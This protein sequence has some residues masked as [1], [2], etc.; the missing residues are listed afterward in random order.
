MS[1]SFNY[2]TTSTTVILHPHGGLDFSRHRP[3]ILEDSNIFRSLKHPHIARHGGAH[4]HEAQRGIASPPRASPPPKFESTTKSEFQF[5][6]SLHTDKHPRTN[7]SSAPP[8]SSPAA[9]SKTPNASSITP[10]PL[11]SSPSPPPQKLLPKP[12]VTQIPL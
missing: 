11:R 10:A 3:K 4:H 9:P 12:P 7:P 8:T 6:E 5:K 2:T 1:S